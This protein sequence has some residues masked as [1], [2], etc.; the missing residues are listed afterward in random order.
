MKQ[1]IVVFL[2]LPMFIWSQTSFEKGKIFFE[3]GKYV[4]AEPLFENY[5]KENPTNSKTIEYLGDIS[6]YEQK[7]NHAIYYYKKLI[8]TF[9]KNANYWFKFGGAL[10]LKAKSIN[11]FKAIGMIDDIEKAF[12]TAAKLDVKHIETRWALVIFYVELPAILGGS[13][14][15]SQKYANELIGISKVDGYLAKGYIDVYFK[16]YQDAEKNYK[17]AREIGDSKTT[18]N[19]LYDLYLNKLKD[20][21]KAQKLKEEFDKKV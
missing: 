5:L 6:G 4:L 21:Q 18:F 19:K 12:L 9:P 10:G 7:W 14:T 13:E 3:Q 8:T 20:K 17:K 11:K 16:R 15:K 1:I 2:L